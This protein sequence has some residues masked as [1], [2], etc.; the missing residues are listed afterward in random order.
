MEGLPVRWLYC[1]VSIHLYSASCSVHQSEVLQVGETQREDSSDDDAEEEEKWWRKNEQKNYLVVGGWDLGCGVAGN[2]LG[3]RGDAEERRGMFVMLE[4]FVQKWWLWWYSVGCRGEKK[5]Q[6]DSV[7]K[8]WSTVN[9]IC[10]SSGF[11]EPS[12]RL[13]GLIVV[14]V[15]IDC[16]ICY[17]WPSLLFWQIV[18][19]VLIGHSFG[20]DWS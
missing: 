19:F 4:Q 16:S 12:K 18:V 10:I 11:C 20:S 9:W 14:F 15:H 8:S 2:E 5:K 7:G 1:I 3:S 6:D 17:D 13:F